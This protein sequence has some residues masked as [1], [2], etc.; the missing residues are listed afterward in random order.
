MWPILMVGLMFVIY[1]YIPVR[2]VTSVGLAVVSSIVTLAWWSWSLGSALPPDELFRG[3][4]WLLF[5]NALGFVA[6]NSLQQP[7]QGICAEPG[8]TAT[9]V[10]R[11][12]DRHPNRR[13]F[14]EALSRE[15][16][17]CARARAPLSR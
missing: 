3:V 17:R 7:A 4:I 13:R 9:V 11:R 14:D 12:A 5:A 1:L 8:A 6:A 16:R 15:W 10:D 2:L